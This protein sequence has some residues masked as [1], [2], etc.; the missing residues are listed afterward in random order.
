[1]TFS[2]TPMLSHTISFR[3]IHSCGLYN[4]KK[5]T[6]T[7]TKNNHTAQNGHEGYKYLVTKILI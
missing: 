4:I 7:T 2:P 5:K 1:M 6:T 3:Q